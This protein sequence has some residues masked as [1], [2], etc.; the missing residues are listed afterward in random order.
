MAFSQRTG[1]SIGMPSGLR[2]S[3]TKKH[4]KQTGSVVHG[5]VGSTANTTMTGAEPLATAPGRVPL[6]DQETP[7]RAP[8]P[9]RGSES[10]GLSQT[11]PMKSWRSFRRRGFCHRIPWLQACALACAAIVLGACFPVYQRSRSWNPEAAVSHV[12]AGVGKGMT[13]GGSCLPDATL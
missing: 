9:D 6:Q 1:P 8:I 10:G 11:E 2:F 4:K 7:S 3:Q 12:L 13:G 5:C